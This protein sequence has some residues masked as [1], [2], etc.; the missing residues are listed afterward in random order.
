LR[1]R[2]PQQAAIAQQRKDFEA[3]I[4]ELKKG[5]KTLVAR[6]K[7]QDAKIQRASDRIELS[8]PAP[9]TALNKQ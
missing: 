6:S 4:T 7:E 2:A 9:Q 3:M 1:G 5:M 8:R